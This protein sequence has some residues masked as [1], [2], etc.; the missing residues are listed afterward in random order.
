MKRFFSPP[1]AG[2][3]LQRKSGPPA[4]TLGP[5][6]ECPEDVEAPLRYSPGRALHADFWQDGVRPPGYKMPSGVEARVVVPILGMCGVGRTCVSNYARQ[7]T[8]FL[9]EDALD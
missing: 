6:A 1:S 4:L 3:K 2:R 9:G 7:L 8:L 5:S